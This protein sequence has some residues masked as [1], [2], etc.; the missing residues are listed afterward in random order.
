M[1]KKLVQ[2]GAGNIGR[3]FIG[4]V[5]SRSGYE[6]V[7]VD[8]D[9]PLVEALNGKRS[10]DVIVKRNDEP[11]EAINITNVRAVDGRD[12]EAVARE[13]REAAVIATSVGKGALPHVL[14]PIAAGLRDRFL[15]GGE[16][17]DIILAENIRDAAELVERELSNRLRPAL[18]DKW[19]LDAH[20]GIVETS[21]GKMVPIMT[22]EDRKR[23]PL[24]VFAEAYNTLIVDKR[25]FRA[26]VPQVMG[27]KA[28]D[29]IRAYVDRKLFV[30]NLGH[31]AAAY[32]GFRHHPDREYLYQ[33]LADPEVLESTRTAMEQS[34][35]ALA[36]EYPA[37]L[38]SDDLHEHIEDLLGRFQNRSLKDTVY[39]VGRDLPRKLSRDDRL[40]GAM[41]VAARHSLPFTAVAAA[42]AA[43]LDFRAADEHGEMFPA[44]RDVVQRYETEGLE[45]ILRDVCELSEAEP[46]DRSVMEEI[47]NARRRPA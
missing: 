7:F 1:E 11:D 23:N 34:A 39:R 31:A 40:V 35:A 22:D 5:F 27:I 25:A 37:D 44:D 14:P 43:A 2:F 16:P 6:V 28:V 18:G 30:H 8:I 33:V 15:A 38:T 47:R 9:E 10:Y 3:S 42:T 29:N 32:I 36:A 12:A 19:D 26:G 17:I 41:L 4:Q 20:V 24:W 13:I 21:I 45:P 46:V